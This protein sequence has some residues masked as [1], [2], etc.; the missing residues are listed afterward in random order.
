MNRHIYIL[1][2]F[3]G[4]ISAQLSVETIK[5]TT[6]AVETSGLEYFKGHFITL[7]DSGDKPNLYSFT[8]EGDLLKTHTIKGTI[9]RDWEDLT[10]DENHIYISDT[11]NNNG[12]RKDLIIYRLDKN[13]TLKDS[14]LIS[15]ANQKKFKKKKKNRYNAEALA[16]VDSVLLLFSKDNKKLTTQVY[17]IPKVPNSYILEPIAEFYV[18]AL[19]TAADYEPISKTLALTADSSNGDQFLYIFSNFDI[20]K[21]KQSKFEKYLIPVNSAQI[22]AIK[23]EDPS[24]FWL[25][26]EGEENGIPRLFKACL[27]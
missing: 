17:S 25:T 4:I 1:F 23:I 9:N 20:L 10:A 27:N 21:I 6:K 11:G 3:S 13:L 7:N 5:M 8:S 14:I 18:N 19:I 16:S 22:E 24:S 12:K 2:L 26:S 15:Y